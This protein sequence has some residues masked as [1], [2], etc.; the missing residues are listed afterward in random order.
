ME[1]SPCRWVEEVVGGDGV[2]DLRCMYLPG[3]IPTVRPSQSGRL[4]VM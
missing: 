1:H 3:K 4:S 2:N